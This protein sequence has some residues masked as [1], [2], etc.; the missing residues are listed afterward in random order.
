MSSTVS[1]TKVVTVI[2]IAPDKNMLP[3]LCRLLWELCCGPVCCSFCQG[4]LHTSVTAALG[5]I[6]IMVGVFNIGLGF[7]RTSTHPGDLAN[8]GAA[9]WLGAVFIVA[10]IM[11]ILA[12]QLNSRCLV[13]F[14]VFMNMSASIFAVTGIVLYAID[15]SDASIRWM[16]EW[17]AGANDC[18]Y[19]A[20][21]TQRLLTS[22]DVTMII[23]AVLQLC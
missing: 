1:K 7:G 23:L 4:L 8:L 18:K 6:Q 9:Y 15:L 12:G 13:G 19:V 16:C 11:C 20:S 21:I 22:M 5:T 14:T 2:T 10:G 17:M 3:P